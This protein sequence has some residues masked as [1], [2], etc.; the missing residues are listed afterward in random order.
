M[1]TAKRAGA[2]L[3]L[4]HASVTS[5][6]SQLT[7][8]PARLT[9]PSSIFSFNC[10][11]ANSEARVDEICQVLRGDIIGLQGTQRR[12]FGTSLF[13]H[14]HKTSH[15]H[16]V[17]IN[18]NGDYFALHWGY[19]VGAFTNK[20]AGVSVL[21]RKRSFH[22][23]WI[24]EFYCPPQA[25]Q[26]RGG[27]VRIRH[28]D[29]DV[30][31]FSVYAPNEPGNSAGRKS[32]Q[33]FY[34]WLFA[35]TA[36]LPKRT[37][38]IFLGDFNAHVGSRGDELPDAGPVIGPYQPQQENSNG[39]M[40][41]QWLGTFGMT[42]AN[43]HFR[44]ASGPTFWSP[45]RQGSRIDYIALPAEN[46]PDVIAI[47][48]WRRA[49][50]QLQI[51]RSATLRD[52]SP[53]HAVISLPRFQPPDN[54]NKMH[55]DYDK[56]RVEMQEI[57]HG[58][59]TASP[60]LS[61][62]AEF[63]SASDS[64]NISARLSDMP[65]PDQNW[66]FI[67]GGLR[68][69]ATKHFAKPPF[70][71]YPITPSARTVE[72]R[73]QA[74]ERFKSF[75]SL[76][77]TP[78]HDWAEGNA[79]TAF[80]L[81][82]A[83]TAWSSIA[84]VT[85]TD[86]QLRNSTRADR[87][88]YY[89]S[90]AIEFTRAAESN[91]S[92]R[93]WIL[94]RQLA[95]TGL[96][97][98]LRQWGA[99]VSYPTVAEWTAFLGQPGNLGGCLAT[100]DCG[101]PELCEH[102]NHRH[103]ATIAQATACAEND[104]ENLATRIHTQKPYKSVPRWSVPAE[105]WRI[106]FEANDQYQSKLWHYR[107][108]IFRM[109]VQIRRTAS[110][111][112]LWH[113]SEAIFLSKANEKSGPAAFRVIHLL[114]PFSKA[115]HASIWGLE[116]HDR[117]DFS[118]GGVSHRRRE[119]ALAQHMLLCWRL[120]YAKVNHIQCFYDIKNAFPSV[121]RDSIDEM[122]TCQFDEP[123]R[124]LLHQHHTDA[125]MNVTDG[126]GGSALLKIG[127]GSMQGDSIGGAIF[128]QVLGPYMTEGMRR[129][130]GCDHHWPFEMDDFL[131]GEHV[132]TALSLYADD[133]S[134]VAKV[135]DAKNAGDIARELFWAVDSAIKP[136]SSSLKKDFSVVP[137]F[138]GKGV[139]A[140][141][142]ETR[143]ISARIR[144]A[145]AAWFALSGLWFQHDVPLK[146]RVRIFKANVMSVLLAGLEAYVLSESQTCKLESWRMA[147]VKNFDRRKRNREDHNRRWRD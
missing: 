128:G 93:M 132:N 84:K 9:K 40:M 17:N 36:R 141:K 134:V 67:N 53:V 72:L 58:N 28:G 25:L 74:A 146:S 117:W 64:Q 7:A 60:F 19:G 1:R 15:L 32:V 119:L 26:G 90:L 114:D 127:S 2:L 123:E 142:C 29:L 23:G 113:Q 122:L 133:V 22:F 118:V 31:V 18:N 143:E 12:Q 39:A 131:T 112:K 80:F 124:E 45:S 87:R 11:A 115:F 33:A 121:S 68:D 5:F 42:A 51:F 96:G 129:I 34:Q 88:K 91:D 71:P 95:R 70:T 89:Q 97:P 47:D 10:F 111:P 20:A 43:T 94:A 73:Q 104:L 98:R 3:A 138:F 100:L 120:E 101:V 65:T 82:S 130:K 99:C 103:E 106:I 140:K 46:L 147:K 8:V 92:H 144:A 79:D 83:L 62:V 21:F 63:F 77:A 30:A 41:R 69:I 27:G 76:P 35:V 102:L 52:H 116:E 4:L 135:S 126:E 108:V 6:N 54:N 136:A 37:M 50:L 57:I 81:R 137:M 14:T 38:N 49:A 48:I 109:L 107:T 145:D 55:W 61:D 44:K 139:Y 16:P 86:R 13:A 59:T 105:V 66:D 56:L 78:I 110:T 85:K 125:V 24:R 75:E